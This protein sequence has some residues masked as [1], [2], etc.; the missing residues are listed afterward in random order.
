[1]EPTPQNVEPTS[2]NVMEPVKDPED[3]EL[4]DEPI[5]DQLPS[6]EEAKANVELDG[7]SPKRSRC[8]L[9][10]YTCSCLCTGV[11]LLLLLAVIIP[12]LEL[13]GNS[14]SSSYSGPATLPP[15]TFEPRVDY[16]R[17]FLSA[18]SDESELKRVGSPQYR[19]SKWIAD[20]DVLHLPIDYPTFVERYALAVFYFATGGPNWPLHLG[21]LTERSTCDWFHI[22]FGADDKPRH[23]GANCQEGANVKQLFFRKLDIKRVLPQ[24]YTQLH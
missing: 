10:F 3:V 5:H 20:E 9:C 23:V 18:F 22:G 7:N 16:V 19:A 4:Q 14:S 6:V 2:P 8:R 24:Q 21:F 11:F 13:R 15:G 12:Q 17:E 1:M